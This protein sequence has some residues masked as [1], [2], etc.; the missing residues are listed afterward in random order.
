MKKLIINADDFGYRDSINKGIVYAHKNGLVTSASLFVEKESVPDAVKLAKENP[1]LGLG[2]HV[3]LDK[4]FEVDH[5]IGL[6]VKL[7][8]QNQ[9]MDEIKSEIRRQLDKFYS[10][11]FTADHIDSH[12]HSHLHAPVLKVTCELAKEF[13]I[14]VV[15]IYDKF[16]SNKSEFETLCKL[17]RESGIR[18]VDH[19]IEGWYWGNVDEQYGIAELMTHPG[20]GEIWREAELG[21]CCQPK[22]R[23]Y[24]VAQKIELIRFSDI[25]NA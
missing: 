6:A 13:K 8:N 9:N 25:N 4:F 12:H 3:D 5:T 14:P 20:Y 1:S 16:Y 19:F 2:L 10:F 11:G 7:L 17:A 22:L 15:R 21:N 23:D 24:L 18:F